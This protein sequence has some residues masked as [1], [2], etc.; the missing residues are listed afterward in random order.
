MISVRLAD[1]LMEQ[2][3]PFFAALQA[4]TKGNRQLTQQDKEQLAVVFLKMSERNQKLA[5]DWM[6]R[7]E[8]P[9]LDDPEFVLAADLQLSEEKASTEDLSPHAQR[10]VDAF[11][12]GAITESDVV[13]ILYHVADFYSEEFPADPDNTQQRRRSR[14]IALKLIDAADLIRK[15]Q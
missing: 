1:L 12:D 4:K 5:Q 2:L 3:N 6:E 11:T 9:L 8:H 7:V 10:F 14:K 15:F 13:E